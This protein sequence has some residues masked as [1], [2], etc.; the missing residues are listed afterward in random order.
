MS[1]EPS[2][3]T[4]SSITQSIKAE[5]STSRR[6]NLLKKLIVSVILVL[7]LL[8]LLL[9]GRERI[10][11]QEYSKALLDLSRQIE[12][13][14][15]Q[16]QR[17]PTLNQFQQFKIDSRNL[18]IGVLT[19][20]I[21][22]IV[23]GSPPETILVYSPMLNSFFYTPGCGIIQLDGRVKRLVEQ[24]FHEKLDRDAK[25]YHSHIIDNK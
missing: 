8:A 20:R 19:Y 23:P 7:M 25:D 17:L 1:P 21:D 10:A 14:K 24:D 9:F 22:Q 3:S 12:S 4:P 13:F 5:Q 11:I 6:H 2:G 16:H 18:S 15:S